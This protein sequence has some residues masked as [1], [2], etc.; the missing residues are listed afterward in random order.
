MC[1]KLPKIESFMFDL[2]YLSDKNKRI[3][4]YLFKFKN[5]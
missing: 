5:N 4:H 3:D 2:P 1:L